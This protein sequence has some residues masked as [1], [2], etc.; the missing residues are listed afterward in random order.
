MMMN[1]TVIVSVHT[2]W[3][4]TTG[5]DLETY[6]KNKDKE[7][8]YD[9]NDAPSGPTEIHKP[10]KATAKKKGGKKNKGKRIAKQKKGKSSGGSEGQVLETDSEFLSKLD[11]SCLIG[12][13]GT[14]FIKAPEIPHSVIKYTSA[15]KPETKYERCES[16]DE[17]EDFRVCPIL[18]FLV[19]HTQFLTTYV[20]HVPTHVKFAFL[21][22]FQES[23]V[24]FGFLD[25][26]VRESKRNNLPAGFVTDT[27]YLQ[28]FNK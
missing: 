23:G 4:H 20:W 24:P 17:C 9:Q 12:K 14:G 21:W 26:I 6:P 1:L 2:K 18:Y 28:T 13:A 5:I 16:G 3:G 15:T 7:E 22:V 8:K 19:Q 11:L 27:I 25:L 10:A